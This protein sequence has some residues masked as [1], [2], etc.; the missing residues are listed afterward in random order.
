MECIV[1]LASYFKPEGYS[2]RLMKYT[3]KRIIFW[4][5]GDY[6]KLIK[7]DKGEERKLISI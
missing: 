3:W 2:K 4:F 6:D 7:G 5:R 1:F